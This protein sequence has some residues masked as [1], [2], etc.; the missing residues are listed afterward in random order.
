MESGCGQ[1]FSRAPFSDKEHGTVNR[2]YPGEFLLKLKEF[3]G[4]T[5]GFFQPYM[6]PPPETPALILRFR[7]HGI[8]NIII[9]NETNSWQNIPYGGGPSQACNYLR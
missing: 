6:G 4:L 2:G 9:E 3:F 1:F 5:Q 7:L 8:L